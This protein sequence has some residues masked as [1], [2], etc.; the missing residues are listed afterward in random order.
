ME[1]F[2]DSH[3]CLNIVK[4]ALLRVGIE[5]GD[6]ID[7]YVYTDG[8][9]SIEQ[10]LENK[11]LYKKIQLPKLSGITNKKLVSLGDLVDRGIES[12]E[13]LILIREAIRIFGDNIIVCSGN[14]E[15]YYK[16][17][18]GNKF[19]DKEEQVIGGVIKNMINNDEIKSNVIYKINDKIINFSHVPVLNKDILIELFNCFKNYDV[20]L[21]KKKEIFNKAKK[22][23]EKMKLLDDVEYLDKILLKFNI[24][25]EEN[26][27]YDNKTDKTEDDKLEEI[28]LLNSFISYLTLYS[29]VYDIYIIAKGDIKSPKTVIGAF[30]CV[31]SDLFF[32]N[33]KL[34]NIVGHDHNVLNTKAGFDNFISL[35][36]DCSDLYG[37]FK[38]SKGLDF[39]LSGD[40]LNI[41]INEIIKNLKKR[42]ILLDN[43]FFKDCSS[44]N[45]SDNIKDYEDLRKTLFE[46]DGFFDKTVKYLKENY[47]EDFFE[48][49]KIVY[50]VMIKN[51]DS[52][53]E[54]VVLDSNCISNINNTLNY[55]DDFQEYLKTFSNGVVGKRVF[56]SIENH[57]LKIELS[58][59]QDYFVNNIKSKFVYFV[60]E[61]DIFL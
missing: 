33:D 47:Y 48:I 1:V 16:F 55:I 8:D 13:S 5:L 10:Q 23:C 28:L 59:V 30:W 9:Y 12:L 54:K 17:M 32:K 4:D 56:L 53:N 43:N 58:N 21:N 49:K 20:D 25:L 60:K 19:R 57:N 7:Y 24:N 22:E 14:H 2:T 38:Y 41:A 45:E 31:Y 40:V 37:L 27:T 39:E 6:N 3:G 51:I 36:L 11:V 35:D 15:A 29:S 44:Y 34:F 52:K 18:R 26:K 42:N 50:K 46:K 61:L